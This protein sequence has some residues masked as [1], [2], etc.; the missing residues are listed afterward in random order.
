MR[1]P[2]PADLACI[3][4]FGLTFACAN[5]Y[6]DR[7]ANEYDPDRPCWTSDGATGVGGMNLTGLSCRDG[8]VATDTSC[9]MD[10]WVPQSAWS[11]TGATTDIS[12][13]VSAADL[14]VP[15]M[16]HEAMD[17]R[18]FPRLESKW[19]AFEGGMLKASV[20][21]NSSIDRMRALGLLGENDRWALASEK[22]YNQQMKAYLENYRLDPAVSGYE[23]WLGFGE[24]FIF[25]CQSKSKSH[26]RSSR[27][28]RSS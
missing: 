19:Q 5:I 18:T 15:M 17:A 6:A 1:L 20:W 9:F 7:F 16:L 26:S 8:R 11:H 13:G 14:P 22:T 23:W 25:H 24:F 28:S 4:G 3:S 2:F 21:L 10:V 12:S 27:S